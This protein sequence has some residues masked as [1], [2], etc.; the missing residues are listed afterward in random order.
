[1][2]DSGP[3][4]DLGLFGMNL[5][6][7][8]Q[9]VKSHRLEE[10]STHRAYIACPRLGNHSTAAN[11]STRGMHGVLRPVDPEF[12]D[13]GFS[14]LVTPGVNQISGMSSKCSSLALASHL[15]R[16]LTL[17]SLPSMMWERSPHGLSATRPVF[18]NA[19]MFVVCLSC[20]KVRSWSGSSVVR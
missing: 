19:G 15:I 11:N 9:H 16:S 2:G 12:V 10:R 17:F 5:Y 14:A 8:S 13:L 18:V 6:P 7:G 1:M 4:P 20:S 3:Q